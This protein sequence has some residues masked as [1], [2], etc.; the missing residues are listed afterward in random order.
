MECFRGCFSFGRD[1]ALERQIQH[2]QALDRQMQ[3]M[4]RTQTELLAALAR[5]GREAPTY[6]APACSRALPLQGVSF[7]GA[8]FCDGQDLAGADMAPKMMRD[9][10]LG[11]ACEQLGWK[12]HDHG[13]VNFD[14]EY[15]AVGLELPSRASYDEVWGYYKKWLNNSPNSNFRDYWQ[16]G[17]RKSL[18]ETLSPSPLLQP[19]STP[20]K[21]DGNINSAE[22]CGPAL[23]AIH[24]KVRAAYSV[25]P[26]DFMLTAGGDHSIAS[27]TIS[28][29]AAR[30][31]DLCVVWVDAHAD[32]NTPKT[33][34]SGNYHGMPAAHVLGWFKPED[35]PKGFDWF[36]EGGCV[37]EQ[38]F[39]LIGLRDVDPLEADALKRSLVTVRTMRDVDQCGISAVVRECL[40]AIDPQGC[41]PIHLSLDVDAI[42]P[43]Y[44]PG[45]GTLARGGLS[46]RE[47]HYIC[48]E[49][50]DTRRLVSMDIVEVNPALDVAEPEA[51]MHGDNP[52]INRSTSTVKL[53]IELVLSSLGKQV[54][55]HQRP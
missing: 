9:A 22:L 32:A 25:R 38:N 23:G 43:T 3:M 11:A 36:P 40:A 27:A 53:A 26:E 7:V 52:A 42:D 37:K 28:G 35:T 34:P 4:M 31:P 41:R 19:V 33:S 21:F 18:D 51:A 13:D 17:H 8:P 29:I 54:L 44:A 24:N 5:P 39:A 15:E 14:K 12:F 48:E 30:Y 46:Y 49:L 6:V 2:T 16:R 50:F 45:T 55:C 1:D 10:G 47:I 20:V